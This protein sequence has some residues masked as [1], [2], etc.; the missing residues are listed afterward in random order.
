MYTGNKILFF[1]SNRHLQKVTNCDANQLETNFRLIISCNHF[2]T[3]EKLKYPLQWTQQQIVNTMFPCISVDKIPHT[4][5]C[6]KST[7]IKITEI[8]TIIIKTIQP[9]PPTQ[10]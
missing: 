5:M 8:A 9:F 6:H 7:R 4:L 10:A 3:M 1:Q 2:I